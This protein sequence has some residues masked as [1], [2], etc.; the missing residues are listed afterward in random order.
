M[1]QCSYCK[2]VGSISIDPDGGGPYVIDDCPTCKGTGYISVEQAYPYSY[3]LLCDAKDIKITWNFD[4]QQADPIHHYFDF[5]K[6]R[7]EL[8][9]LLKKA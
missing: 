6:F 7:E 8:E 2:G 1:P 4:E 3:A 5:A 9:K